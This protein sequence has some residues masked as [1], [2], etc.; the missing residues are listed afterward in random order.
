VF[1]SCKNG[2]VENEELYKLNS[3]A[4][5]FGGRYAKKVLVAPALRYLGSEQLIKERAGELDIR[6]VDELSD[7]WEK[8]CRT[9]GSFWSNT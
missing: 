4:Q 7:N 6:V 3:V 9:V 2:I 5:Y 8:L 1:V